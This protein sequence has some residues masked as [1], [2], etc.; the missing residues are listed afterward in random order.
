MR[1]TKTVSLVTFS[2]VAGLIAP[3]ALLGSHADS[4][5]GE[6]LANSL[7]NQLQQGQQN[8]HTG[9]TPDSNGTNNTGNYSGNVANNNGGGNNNYQYQSG[10]QSFHGYG[11]GTSDSGNGSSF[12]NGSSTSD[13]GDSNNHV[14]K[15]KS[16]TSDDGH[17][18][19]SA[20]EKAARRANAYLASVRQKIAT[21]TANNNDGGA[22]DLRHAYE[23]QLRVIAN[24][25][26]TAQTRAL[27][28]QLSGELNQ[29]QTDHDRHVAAFNQEIDKL[30]DNHSTDTKAVN[31]QD[32]IDYEDAKL[33]KKQVQARKE[34][35][36]AIKHINP[37]HK[38]QAKR[39]AKR[40]YYK[41]LKAKGLK[42]PYALQRENKRTWKQALKHAQEIREDY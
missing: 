4:F 34:N 32:A 2:L 17:V 35:A 41:Q 13:D 27:Q 37:V 6:H 9:G 21:R 14:K 42:D 39:K 3:A 22:W 33:A 36:Q 24:G 7:Y 8:N 38:K 30:P 29:L 28:V 31:L 10:D 18:E 40:E 16:S 20:K 23:D 26:R 19:V 12:D 11:S 15:S 25:T 1:L 5:D